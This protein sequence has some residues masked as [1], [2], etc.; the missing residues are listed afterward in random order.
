MIEKIA[1]KR[2]EL[3][4]GRVDQQV[5]SRLELDILIVGGGQLSYFLA[6]HL[7]AL[8]VSFD[9]VSLTAERIGQ[10][11]ISRLSDKCV[12]IWLAGYSRPSDKHKST[13]EYMSYIQEYYKILSLIYGKSFSCLHCVHFGSILQMSQK[14][15]TLP[16]VRSK[17]EVSKFLRS[18]MRSVSDFL[19]PN[20]EGLL[21]PYEHWLQTV[22]TRACFPHRAVQ[23]VGLLDV[24]F[25]RVL[26][27]VETSD[28][29]RVVI[30]DILDGRETNHIYIADEGL[31]V[32]SLLTRE[33]RWEGEGM[34]E[35]I[36]YA[37]SLKL[38]PVISSYSGFDSSVQTRGYCEIDVSDVPFMLRICPSLRLTKLRFQFSDSSIHGKECIYEM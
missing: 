16:Y 1:R 24:N 7:L 2:N 29:A 23:Q 27:L 13:V 14:H 35:G 10:Q 25:S 33:I 5:N 20:N 6:S 12:V 28:L 31:S 3:M 26:Y 8:G 32:E 36:H 22:L 21:R 18:R 19:I 37:M 11:R 34:S 4:L 15:K 17:R 38:S 30:Q 9:I